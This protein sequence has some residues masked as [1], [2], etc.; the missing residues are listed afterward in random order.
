[1]DGYVNWWLDVAFNHASSIYDYE[2]YNPRMLRPMT[3]AHYLS[4]PAGDICKSQ[5][6][7]IVVIGLQKSYAET[8]VG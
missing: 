2:H 5:L 6:M 7:S 8:K 3:T 4:T 1:M